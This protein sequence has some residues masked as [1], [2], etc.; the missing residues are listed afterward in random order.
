M[1][2]LYHYGVKGQKWGVIRN[3][4]KSS[5]SSRSSG[6]SSG[7]SGRPS[8]AKA[9][10]NSTKKNF[11]SKK[12]KTTMREKVAR[13]KASVDRFLQTDAG[14]AVKSA[15]IVGL[16]VAGGPAVL[17]IVN[18][19]VYGQSPLRTLGLDSGYESMYTPQVNLGPRY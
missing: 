9:A 12:S 17:S 8:S 3:R 11:S 13:G 4:D 19:A 18:A 15:A 10:V 14:R 6:K 2:E 16:A 7:S 5:G 1:D